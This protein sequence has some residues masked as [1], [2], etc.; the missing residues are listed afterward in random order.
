MAIKFLS[1]TAWRDADSVH[2]PG[3]TSTSGHP[4]NL[5][6]GPRYLTWKWTWNSSLESFYYKTDD[7]TDSIQFDMLAI[8][9]A[10]NLVGETFRFQS[11]DAGGATNHDV[12]TLSSGDLVG[13]DGEDYVF[14]IGSVTSGKR[15]VGLQYASGSPTLTLVKLYS[16]YIG[17]SVS[18]EYPQGISIEPF[19][20]S[21]LIGRTN[22]KTSEHAVMRFA[23]VTRAELD[24]IQQMYRLHTD[25]IF[26]Y[27]ST[28]NWFS[29][30]LWHCLVG[31]LR[32][33][34]TS[35]DLFNVTFD[36][37]RIRNYPLVNNSN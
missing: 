36:L 15:K 12:F 3:L 17:Q 10:K 24:S 35:D 18:L 1:N 8:A 27:D 20:N 21:V 13:A 26:V 34:A 29:D 30:K 33:E 19:W 16:V 11:E 9:G 6:Y 5:T 4:E 23:G 7:N 14:D 32:S 28:G 31:P 37:Y 22:Y 2:Y 25:P